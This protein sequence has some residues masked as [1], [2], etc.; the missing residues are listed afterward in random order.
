MR[1]DISQYGIG[2]RESDRLA[3][4]Q[5]LANLRGGHFQGCLPDEGDLSAAA[6]ER[7]RVRHAARGQQITQFL[8]CLATGIRSLQHEDVAV[9][10]QLLPAMPV[11][12]PQKAS[13]PTTS[14]NWSSAASSARSDISVSM[15]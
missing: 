9:I 14:S 4:G 2:N 12:S 3:A 1:V 13:Q 5:Q 7:L 15:V 11:G 10:E 6:A 8:R